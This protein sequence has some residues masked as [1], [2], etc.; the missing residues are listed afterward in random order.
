MTREK[1][2]KTIR[3]LN[4]K[5]TGG[6]NEKNTQRQEENRLGNEKTHKDEKKTE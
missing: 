2:A 6:E 1:I 5:Q 3:K 4:R